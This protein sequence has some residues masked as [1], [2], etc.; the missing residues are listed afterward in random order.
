M[1]CRSREHP[2]AGLP[3]AQRG[4]SHETAPAVVLAE[5]SKAAPCAT[6]SATLAGAHPA[7]ASLGSVR[8]VRCFDLGASDRQACISS[9]Y[10]IRQRWIAAA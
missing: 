2:Q 4:S 8:G 10:E 6:R 5:G 7:A 9:D 3:Q 1:H